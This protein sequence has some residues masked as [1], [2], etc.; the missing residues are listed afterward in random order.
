MKKYALSIL[1]CSGIAYP[2]AI[3]K[4]NQVKS[5]DVVRLISAQGHVFFVPKD[6]AELSGTIK[7]LLSEPIFEEARES[8]IT[9]QEIDTQTLGL[10]LRA[11][12][13]QKLNISVDDKRKRLNKLLA[14]AS[15]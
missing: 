7:F 2:A 15:K 12:H 8:K 4:K 9:L 3:R 1:L 10:L 6:V 13:N 5:I 14:K 11:L